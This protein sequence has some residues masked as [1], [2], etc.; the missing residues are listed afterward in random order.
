MSVIR[1]WVVGPGE[2]VPGCAAFA[3]PGVPKKLSDDAS[4]SHCPPGP[5]LELAW[6]RAVLMVQPAHPG[7]IYCCAC[8]EVVDQ[9]IR[10]TEVVSPLDDAVASERQDAGSPAAP[11]VV[12]PESGSDPTGSPECRIVFQQRSPRAVHF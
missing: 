1:D 2:R 9:R 4:V 7:V 11:T 5:R 3:E 12:V 10:E 6:G 8:G